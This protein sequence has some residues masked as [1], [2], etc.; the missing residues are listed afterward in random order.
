M[1]QDNNAFRTD[2]LYHFGDSSNYSHDGANRHEGVLEMLQ[3]LAKEQKESE[4]REKEI[5]QKLL[6]GEL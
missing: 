1:K 2:F 5:S 6:E 4:A 3:R